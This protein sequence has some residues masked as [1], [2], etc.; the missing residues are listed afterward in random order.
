VLDVIL[1]CESST[2]SELEKCT[3]GHYVAVRDEWGVSESE[4]REVS[5]EVRP[6]VEDSAAS[7]ACRCYVLFIALKLIHLE[8]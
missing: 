2:E 4:I 1:R 7:S 6:I 8:Q 5:V 3:W